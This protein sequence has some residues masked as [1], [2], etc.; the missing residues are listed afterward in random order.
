MIV[1]LIGFHQCI[2]YIDVVL[3][4]RFIKQIIDPK[5][6]RWNYK[7]GGLSFF[8][9]NFQF[10]CQFSEVLIKNHDSS[11]LALVNPI[12]SPPKPG[13]NGRMKRK[14]SRMPGTLT[15]LFG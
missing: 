8:Q 10:P 4:I 1:Y 7:I 14:R 9:V 3:M 11:H 6:N 13:Q 5:T 12:N 2:V 15:G